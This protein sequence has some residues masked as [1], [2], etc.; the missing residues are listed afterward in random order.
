V[1]RGE[2][3]RVAAVRQSKKAARRPEKRER[4]SE[5]ENRLVV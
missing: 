2:R 1:V 3:G 4:E 5:R